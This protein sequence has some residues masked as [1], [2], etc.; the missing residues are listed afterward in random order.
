VVLGLILSC[1]KYLLSSSFNFLDKITIRCIFE[2]RSHHFFSDLDSIG[3][4]LYIGSEKVISSSTTG[5]NVS[6]TRIAVPLSIVSFSS[7]DFY[8]QIRLK[9]LKPIDKYAL[10]NVS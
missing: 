6:S 7:T 1:S 2:K 5:S 8:S 10:R 9:S 3:S 4:W